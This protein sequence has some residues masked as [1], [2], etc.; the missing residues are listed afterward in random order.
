MRLRLR[1]LVLYTWIIVFSAAVIF[2]LNEN[3]H[4]INDIQKE[5]IASCAQT[6]RSIRQTLIVLSPAIQQVHAPYADINERLN[7]LLHLF[8]P[9]N[10][11]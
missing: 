3:R 2:A 7:Y 9:I 1:W 6:Y 11:K 4:R 10:C 8:D 5:R